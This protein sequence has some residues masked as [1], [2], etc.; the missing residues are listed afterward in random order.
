MMIADKDITFVVQGAATRSGDYSVD[1]C[2]NSIRKFF[3]ESSVVLSTWQGSDVSN[4]GYDSLVENEDPGTPHTYLITGMRPIFNKPNQINRQ[5]ASSFNGLKSVKTKYAIKIRSD[6]SLKSRSIVGCYEELA[7]LF[8]KRNKDWTV[9]ESPILSPNLYIRNPNHMMPFAYHISDMIHIGLT[10]DLLKLWDCPLMTKEY[11]AFFE[12]NLINLRGHVIASKHTVEQYLWIECLMKNG[13]NFTKSEHYFDISQ[14]ILQDSENS[15]INNFYIAEYKKMGLV[16]KFDVPT[17]NPE[18]C[19]TKEQVLNLY[20]DYI[21]SD[22]ENVLKEL[23]KER[24]L[25]RMKRIIS[26]GKYYVS[27]CGLTL[28]ITDSVLFKN[29][30]ARRNAAGKSLIGTIIDRLFRFGKIKIDFT[31]LG[32]NIRN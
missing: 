7:K 22:D 14:D 3:P 8:P 15:I 23:K 4:L 17:H 25:T 29:Y 21:D 27:I 26:Y 9:F 5:I 31:I 6:F 2:I 13:I 19:Y 18:A 16:S 12:K 30:L 11:A 32:V 1:A 28:D 20:L 10:S 24:T